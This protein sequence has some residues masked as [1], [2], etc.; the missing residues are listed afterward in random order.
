MEFYY[1][2]T[3]RDVLI[4]RADG[5]IDSHNAQEFLSQLQRL[6]EAGARK[7]LVDCSGL[8]YLSSFGITTLIRLHKRMAERG[9]HVKLAAVK[10]PLFRLLEITRLNEVFQTYPSVE[11][12]LQAFREDQAAGKA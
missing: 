7:L 8:G 11:A 9:G 5:G 10:S 3:D 4:L 6:I 1:R 12:A 2:D